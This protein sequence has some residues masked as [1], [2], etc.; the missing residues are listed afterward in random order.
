MEKILD[1]LQ[2]STFHIYTGNSPLTYVRESKLGASQIQWL[3]ELALFD[4]NIH[5]Q[6][7]S[8]NKTADALS[9]HPHTEEETKIERGSD[10]DEVEAISYPSVSEVVDE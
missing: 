3:S 6:T 10:C 2:D 1:Y 8:S 4:F 5:Y 9:R 7:R